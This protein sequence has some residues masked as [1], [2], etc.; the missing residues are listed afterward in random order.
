MNETK[1]KLEKLKERLEIVQCL[2]RISE[3]TM[4][5]VC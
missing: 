4:L 3:H 5:A 1:T 2:W